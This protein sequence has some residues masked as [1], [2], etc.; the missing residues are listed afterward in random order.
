ML[1]DVVEEDLRQDYPDASDMQIRQVTLAALEG[2]KPTLE[3]RA[4]DVVAALLA[5]DQI[6]K[7]I[8]GAEVLSSTVV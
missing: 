2:L 4:L 8:G 7:G 3:A 6:R 1:G 5:G